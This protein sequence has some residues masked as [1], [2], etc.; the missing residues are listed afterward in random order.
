[1]NLKL[2]VKQSSFLTSTSLPSSLMKGPTTTFSAAA[3]VFVFVLMYVFLVVGNAFDI[4]LAFTTMLA[5][6][7]PGKRLSGI[8]SE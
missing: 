1:M 5:P 6:V 3:D 8:L 7:G 4:S 2:W